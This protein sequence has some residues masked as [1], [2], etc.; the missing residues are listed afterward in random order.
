MRVGRAPT[1][2]VERAARR[3]APRREHPHSAVAVVGLEKRYGDKVV[4]DDVTFDVNAGEIVAL[5][6]PNGAGK[7]TTLEI[8]EGLR[9][10]DAG[11]VRLFGEPV[12]RFTQDARLR[13]LLGVVLQQAAVDPY[14]CV[15]ELVD[16]HGSYFD[17]RMS[18]DEVLAALGLAA[19]R[20][21]RVTRLSGGQRRRLDIALGVVGRPHLLFLD[22]PT[23][24]LDAEARRDTWALVRD[25]R[26]R[27]TAVLLTTHYIEEAHL[28]ADRVVVI[29]DGRIL[30]IDTPT[31]IVARS[32]I[33]SVATVDAPPRA[34][35][36][37]GGTRK[38]G[39]VR[40]ELTDAPRQLRGLIEWAQRRNVQ[41]DTLRVTPPTLEEAYLA[42]IGVDSGLV[43]RHD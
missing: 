39:S 13:N 36:P 25:L 40:L 18:T 31:G 3:V 21:T 9:T 2:V 10:P 42:L 6:G 7:T 29:A 24:G 17:D 41:L 27:G 37:P 4:V 14:L 43:G 22:E 35:S 12:E 33:P 20:R 23:T 16:L 38:S 15:G 30:A 32:A 5:L 19:A 34:G 11:T 8:I 28:L 1:K 26:A